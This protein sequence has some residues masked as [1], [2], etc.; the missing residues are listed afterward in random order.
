MKDKSESDELSHI[1]EYLQN[2]IFNFN[3]IYY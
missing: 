1:S 3:Y 2:Y